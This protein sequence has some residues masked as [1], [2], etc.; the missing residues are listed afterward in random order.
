MG[1]EDTREIFLR[2]GDYAFGKDGTVIRTLLGSCVAVTFWYPR[3]KL[4]AMCHYLLPSRHPR[5]VEPPSGKYARDVI[6]IIAD[7]FANQGLDPKAFE[8]K[9]FGG[10]NMFPNLTMG[11]A[12][13]VGAKNIQMGIARLTEAGFAIHS[14]DLAGA[15]NRTVI[16]DVSNGDVW[17]RQGQPLAEG[18][19]ACR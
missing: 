10:S 1:G 14:F 2:P 15:T 4:G 17:V 6:P 19:G 5:M 8:V 12:L 3:L 7:R 9:M 11:E 16:F 18:K 13:H